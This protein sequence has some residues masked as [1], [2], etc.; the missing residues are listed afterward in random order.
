[1]AS[2]FA[3]GDVY[4]GAWKDGERDATEMYTWANGKDDMPH[5]KVHVDGG[6]LG[7]CTR[8]TTRMGMA[9]GKYTFAA[10]EVYVGE[11][12][13][14]MEYERRTRRPLEGGWEGEGA[15]QRE[16]WR[17][18]AQGDWKDG[19][20]EGNG[21]H[22]DWMCTTWEDGNMENGG[23]HGQVYEGDGNVGRGT[24]EARTRRSQGHVYEGEY[25]DGVAHGKGTI[26]LAT[27]DTWEG[28][29]KDGQMRKV[30]QYVVGR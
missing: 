29:W 17:Q 8:A 3:N 23:V 24:G 28:E 1:M 4:E 10:G 13:D 6:Q 11:W 2:T 19:K 15:R 20:R 22:V 26:T 5:G 25:K 12:K 7:M 30:F 9:H 18:L 14:G 27:G 21:V 16:A